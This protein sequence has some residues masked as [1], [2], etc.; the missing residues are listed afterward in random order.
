MADDFVL[1]VEKRFPSG[2]LLE[3]ELELPADPPMVTV[4]FGPSASG[5]TT[6]LRCLAGLDKP[7]RGIIRHGKDAWFDS[8]RGVWQ[9]PQRRRLGYLFQEYALFPHQTVR[10][11]L[12]YGLPG[13]SR[14]ERGT[15]LNPLIDL[16]QLAGLQDR[17]PRQLSGGEKQRV[18]LAR[19]L[20]PRPQLLLLDEP[21][22][23]LDAPSRG[24]LRNDLRQILNH[25]A[26]PTLLVTHDRVEALALGDR[27]AVLADGR[28]QQIGPVQ[29][30]FSLPANHTVAQS[31]GM[32]T[33]VPGEIIGEHN[34]LISVRAGPVE[35]NC[36]DPGDLDGQE[37][38]VCIRGEDVLLERGS[39]S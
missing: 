18:A 35:F 39:P 7:D 27:L 13:G 9:Q 22:S 19:A 25:I 30:V 28:I 4:L 33:L 11:N 16:F 17:Y 31:V 38:Y 24:R 5:K 6:L 15:R 2:F 23:A 10:Q 21:L 14:V 36:I 12:E 26:V 34:G 37:V 8:E 1:K 3:A 32:D 29:D 20:A